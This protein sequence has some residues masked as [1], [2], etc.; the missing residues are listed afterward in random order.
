[1][2][3]HRY[4]CGCIYREGVSV[5]ETTKAGAVQAPCKGDDWVTCG[6]HRSFESFWTDPDVKRIPDDVDRLVFG[7]LGDWMAAH[8]DASVPEETKRRLVSKTPAESAQ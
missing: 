1:M 2:I 4:T 6:N 5:E 3:I 7:I 8:C